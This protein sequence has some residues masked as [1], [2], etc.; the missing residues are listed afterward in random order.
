ML[1]TCRRLIATEAR[2]TYNSIVSHRKITK[3]DLKD[4][5]LTY[6]AKT[7]IS[8][9]EEP[10][11]AGS[12]M[13]KDYVSPF[14]ATIIDLLDASGHVML[15]K[16][17]LDEFGMGSS[18]TYTTHGATKNPRY[19][20]DR[21][22][23]GSS[24]GSAAAIAGNLADFA[25]GTDTGGSVRQPASYCGI[26]G[27]KPTYG[28]IS[29]YGVIPYAQGFDTVGILARKVGTA[30]TVFDVLD[31][32]DTKDIT[33]LPQTIREK[34]R[35]N[36]AVT[37][38]ITFGV[39]QELLL[40][41]LNEETAEQ[42]ENVL[43][44]LMDI[45]HTVRPVSIPTIG[46]SLLAYYTLATSDAASNLARFDGI[47]YGKSLSEASGTDRIAQNRSAGLGPEVQRRIIVGNYSLLSE[48]E[49]FLLKATE[50]RRKLVGELNDVFAR[51]NHLTGTEGVDGGCD[52]LLCPTAFGR[53]PTIAEV[54]SDNQENFLNE[55]VNDI[56]TVPASMAGLPA[57]SVPCE[58]ADFGIQV[59][60]QHGDD[61]N[62]LEVAERIESLGK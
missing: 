10:T 3:C 41:E 7:N 13:L 31:E 34:F 42:F 60:G 53:A 59:M 50:L 19:D 51:P 20:D 33:S 36:L 58:N 44:K 24:G 47:R 14:N 4:D 61:A 1:R 2:D 9:T 16:T 52:V 48:S 5:K 57:I 55:F 37:D 18:T 17:N 43:A 38:K 56:L 49:N 32:F 54:R 26:I 12:S 46:K 30:K 45:G 35:E 22:A 29:R 62:V 27:F 28:R 39:P 21:T 15:G 25:L 11:T 23:G 8:T 40:A 6:L